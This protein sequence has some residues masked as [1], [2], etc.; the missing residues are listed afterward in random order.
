[1]RYLINCNNFKLHF[2]GEYYLI[3]EL[4]CYSAVH[5]IQYVHMEGTRNMSLNE[6]I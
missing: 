6:I 3:Y 4:I 2:Y 1:M 5:S